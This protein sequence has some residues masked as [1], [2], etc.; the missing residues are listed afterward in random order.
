MLK[1]F[2]GL[3]CLKV[4]IRELNCPAGGVSLLAR[5]RRQA[6]CMLIQGRSEDLVLLN[7]LMKPASPAL[8]RK[9]KG[10]SPSLTCRC[11]PILF[12]L[13]AGSY[14]YLNRVLF[15]KVAL[16]YIGKIMSKEI[17]T[18]ATFCTFCSFC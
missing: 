12:F 18:N 4:T 8:N 3:D 11:D 9:T 6:N 13:P 7:N 15:Q 14:A 10:N 17:C 2:G 5:K 16:N 1:S